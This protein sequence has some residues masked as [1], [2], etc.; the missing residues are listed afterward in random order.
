M[1]K[2][3]IVPLV[4]LI[5]GAAAFAGPQNGN[6][7]GGWNG[8]QGNGTTAAAT[9]TTISGKLSIVNSRIAL[10]SSGHTYYI[11]GLNQLVG[12]VDGLQEGASVTLEGYDMPMTAAPEYS[13]FRATKLTFK[14]TDYDLSAGRGMRN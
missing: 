8:V 5:T 14:G 1:K 6:V 13:N 11:G 3:F 4:L 2:L 9:T 10:V 7:R 12:F